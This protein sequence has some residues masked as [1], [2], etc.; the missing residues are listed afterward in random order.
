M[1]VNTSILVKLD[2]AF[3]IVI[4]LM[5]GLVAYLVFNKKTEGKL[6][7]A[8]QDVKKRVANALVARTSN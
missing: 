5:I 2:W 4:A 8:L 3:W 6:E 7:T 1:A